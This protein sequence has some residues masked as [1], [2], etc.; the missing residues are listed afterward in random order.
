MKKIVFESE[1]DKKR[2][3]ATRTTKP[4]P[5]GASGIH[6][7]PLATEDSTDPSA[8]DSDSQPRGT[9]KPQAKSKQ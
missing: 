5:D 9:K 8:T 6:K 7:K 1:L 3:T 4:N 2:Y